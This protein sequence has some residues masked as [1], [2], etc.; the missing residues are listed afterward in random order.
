ME[1]KLFG[2]LSD[3]KLAASHDRL[4]QDPLLP[5]NAAARSEH[6]R[7]R[8]GLRP[9]LDSGADLFHVPFLS[10]CGR[11]QTKG[12]C[13]D[14]P[15]RAAAFRVPPQS[16]TAEESRQRP[17]ACRQGWGRRRPLTACGDALRPRTQRVR[18]TTSHREARQ[19]AVR[20]RARASFCELGAAQGAH[21]VDGAPARGD[22]RE[23]RG[24]N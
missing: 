9:R 12:E 10:G 21:R 11:R 5:Q 14:R 16:R 7:P 18:R 24:A 19:R 23:I 8:K 13:H 3:R 1:R 6:P 2:R 4:T 20:H 22:R 15:Y 17:V